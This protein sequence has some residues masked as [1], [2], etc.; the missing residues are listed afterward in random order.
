MTTHFP[1]STLIGSQHPHD[2]SFSTEDVAD[3]S[4]SNREKQEQQDA[5]KLSQ[6]KA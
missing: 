1:K 3:F 5:A 2:G 6:P 4:Q